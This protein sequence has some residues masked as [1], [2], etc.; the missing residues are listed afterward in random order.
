MKVFGVPLEQL[1]ENDRKKHSDLRIPYIAQSTLTAIMRD[2]TT[3]L[4]PKHPRKTYRSIR[5][6]K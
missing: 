2:G 5:M 4:T 1:T 6:E 3:Y